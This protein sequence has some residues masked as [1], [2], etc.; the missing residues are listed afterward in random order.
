MV[1][2][3]NARLCS[4]KEEICHVQQH[5]QNWR[6]FTTSHQVHYTTK[7]RIKKKPKNKKTNKQKNQ[8]TQNGVEGE[9]AR[10][11]RCLC[12]KYENQV[13]TPEP[14]GKS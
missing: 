6:T 7:L 9:M 8:K 11:V 13:Q 10:L 14:T 3:H 1:D 4:Q 12:Y 5:G 2:A